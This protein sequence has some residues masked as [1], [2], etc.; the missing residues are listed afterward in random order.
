[1]AAGRLARFAERAGWPA[2]PAVLADPRVI[3]AFCARGLAGW[4][5]A[6]RGTYRSVLRAWAGL[7]D[8]G[9]ARRGPGYP[10]SRAPRPYSPGERAELAA[11]GA[12]QRPG[13][14]ASALTMIAAGFGAGL[15]ASEL[16]ALRG[17]DVDVGV[18]VGGEDVVVAVP[19]RRCRRVPVTAPYDIVL[20]ELARSAAD[21]VLFR[22]GLADRGYKNAVCGL[23]ETLTCDPEAPKFRLGRARAS[24]I[25]DH[26]AA[27]TAVTALLAITGIADAASL[28]RYATWVDG[29]P[30]SKG[31]WRARLVNEQHS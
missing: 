5:S 2:E 6:T 1:M 26:I 8:G 21:Q 10:G 12:A 29:A 11:I 30:A 14:R 17:A 4:S 25:C 13:R 19:G 20:A 24:F 9:R 7:A 22:P 31:A 18:G 27:G 16:M 3:E 15:T 23:A 28:A